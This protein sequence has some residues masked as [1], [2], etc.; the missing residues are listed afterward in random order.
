M[1]DDVHFPSFGQ[2]VAISLLNN[3]SILVLLRIRLLYT[4]YYTPLTLHRLLYSAYFKLD[5]F[6]SRARE[7]ICLHL[8]TTTRMPN[9]TVSQIRFQLLSHTS[10]K[11]AILEYINHLSIPFTISIHNR[12][13][14]HI[15]VSITN[16]HPIPTQET[17]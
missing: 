2:D 8:L 3:S 15:S 16:A 9:T 10:L 14:A 17:T 7:N 11:G 4:A 1:T 6:V 13:Q 12:L 5:I